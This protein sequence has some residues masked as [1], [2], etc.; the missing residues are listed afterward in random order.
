MK[1]K[2]LQGDNT[3]LATELDKLSSISQ[4]PGSYEL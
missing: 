3:C 2:Y 1:E 4:I